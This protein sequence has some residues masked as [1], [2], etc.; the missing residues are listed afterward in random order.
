MRRRM[1]QGVCGFLTAGKRCCGACVCVCVAGAQNE[2]ARARCVVGLGARACGAAGARAARGK[3]CGAPRGG[4]SRR[5][6][7]AK[8]VRER[9]CA[10]LA[11][12]LP[13]RRRLHARRRGARRH[14]SARPAAAAAGGAHA[15]VS[16]RP[17]G[18]QQQRPTLTPRER[19]S[20]A[21]GRVCVCCVV[22]RDAWHKVPLRAWPPPARAPAPAC[23]AAAAAP[24]RRVRASARAA[25]S[26][27]HA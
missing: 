12:Q 9:V 15:R 10:R 16:A 4:R 26:R 17:Q 27:A 21:R 14:L 3:A 1:R 18:G 2:A 8:R 13:V 25:P 19:E 22:R 20:V 7:R 6:P 11:L 5:L 24:A 23:A